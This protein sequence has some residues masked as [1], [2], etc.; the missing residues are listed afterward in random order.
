MVEWVGLIEQK[1]KTMSKRINCWEFTGCGRNPGG[2]RVADLGLCPASTETR[3]QGVNHG[4]QGG[5]A[6]W[7]LTGTL[8]GNRVQGTF[9][10][11]LGDCQQCAFFQQ[12]RKDEGEEYT[13]TKA[14]LRQ[15]TNPT[16][17]T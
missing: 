13:G 14:I 6:C 5:R 8:C 1:R 11:K 10:C 15:L 9:A 3:L 17:N 16:P 2:E 4:D 7:A 12:V